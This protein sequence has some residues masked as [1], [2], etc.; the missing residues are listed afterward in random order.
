MRKAEI[1]CRN[2]FHIEPTTLSNKEYCD[3][4]KEAQWLMYSLYPHLHPDY[5]EPK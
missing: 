2:L 1:Y 4:L 5:K 3:R